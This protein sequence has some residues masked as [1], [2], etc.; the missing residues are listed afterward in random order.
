MYG[1]ML[2][3]PHGKS[4]GPVSVPSEERERVRSISRLDLVHIPMLHHASAVQPEH[5]RHRR[6][7]IS[8]VQMHE[9]NI[10]L[11]GLV[12]N[13]PAHAGDEVL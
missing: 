6:G 8:D 13:G 1:D 4:F 2:K 12:D 7:S 3:P 5:I 10:A 11:K 9:P